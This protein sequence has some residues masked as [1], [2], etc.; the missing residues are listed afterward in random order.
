[1]V[2]CPH[3]PVAATC[4]HAGPSVYGV[5]VFSL[6][7]LI[8]FHPRVRDCT[9]SWTCAYHFYI[10]YLQKGTITIHN[11]SKQMSWFVLFEILT[12]KTAGKAS[13]LSRPTFM[14]DPNCP[15]CTIGMQHNLGCLSRRMSEVAEAAENFI[16]PIML[17]PR[18]APSETPS[19]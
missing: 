3:L 17:Q 9:Q 16:A 1:M 11:N 12:V 19:N 18:A 2:W 14:L 13:F 7:F 5:L 15:P 10:I 4:W 8:L 6:L